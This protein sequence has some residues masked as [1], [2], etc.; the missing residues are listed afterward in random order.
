[1][2][3]TNATGTNTAAAIDF[4]KEWF[5]ISEQP[6]FF[7][8]LANE[9][10]DP[11]EPDERH[12]TT[13]DIEDVTGF[14]SKWNRPKRGSFFCVATL[15]PNTRRNKDNACEICGLH[16]DIDFKDVI[17]DEATILRRLG[18]L[19]LPPSWIVN[20]GNGY[21][22]YWAFKES[23]RIN[24]VDGHETIER[25]EAALKLLCDLVG[26]D[27]KV[28]H[29][30]ALMRMPGTH[31]SKRDEW[32]P[33]TVV[34]STGHRYELDDIETMLSE[35][36]P[37]VLRK[38]RPTS[39]TAGENDAFAKYA[40]EHKLPIDVGQRLKAM[41]YMAGGEAAV[42]TTQLS[43]SASM[44]SSGCTI[45][46]VVAVV[47]GATRLAAGS[48]GE[49]WNWKYEE[50]HTIRGMCESWLR[51]HPRDE[52]K[53]AKSTGTGTAVNDIERLNR[54]HALLPISG[55]TRVV[56]FGELEDFP[57][58][59]T[60]VMTQTIGD[61]VALQNK[62]RHEY[63]DKEGKAQSIPM[64]T[65]WVG[66]QHR[67][68]YD[69]GMAF[70]PQHNKDTVGN[71]MNLWRGYGVR[72]IKPDGKSGAQGC[73]KFLAFMRDVICGGNA[74]HFDYL[75]KREATILQKRIRSEIALGLRSDEEGAGKG[76][77]ERTM[78]HLLGGHAM[79]VGNAKHVVGAFN[80]HLETLLRLTADEA[81]FV[82]NHEHRNVLFGLVTESKLTIEPKGFGIYR[83]DSFLNISVTSNERHFLPVSG[84][85]RRFF[86]PTISQAHL[87]DFAYF[88]AILDQLKNE[89]GY[90]ALLYHFLHEV[91]LTG[92]NVRAVPKT[93]G[94]M[95]QRNHSLLPLEAW[96][97][98]L[99]ETGTIAGADPLE[100]NRAVSHTYQREVTIEAGNGTAQTRLVNQL[101]VYDQAKQVEPRLKSLSDHRLG[102]FLSQM[103][104]ENRV[105]VLRRRGWTFPPLLQCRDEWEK[106]FPNWPWVDPA[107]EAWRAEEADDPVD[108]DAL[109]YE[110]RAELATQ[111]ATWAAAHA[112]RLAKEAEHAKANAKFQPAG[113]KPSRDKEPRF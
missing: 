4:V 47:L 2:D 54:L 14:L 103:G 65:Y 97:C 62:Y 30:A 88:S 24:I 57:G 28:C 1:M 74:E 111:A 63:L 27:F 56:T 55:K 99:L 36:S 3:K 22:C 11:T 95:E 66:S 44:L 101:G 86:I 38:E 104:C 93:E 53:Q 82:G 112:E 26:G 71:R 70:M 7:N 105:K 92:F 10:G 91:D 102:A 106:R 110:A 6:A 33:V 80:P 100:P 87:Q 43:V 81:L 20:S 77:Y 59:E 34:E 76:I 51:K 68:Q 113:A 58:R 78:G 29:V 40:S 107:I 83:A 69:G 35:T 50:K 94:L 90:E 16:A 85:A 21:H 31:N 39:K 45:D 18:Q 19:L 84:T 64:G 49:R 61:F 48:Y 13:R 25:I 32:K 98:E 12:V 72:A 5:G 60:I 79:Q 96:W 8:S 52:N 15:Q 108:L 89:G 41:S 17:D 9:K 67:R 75:V 109:T 37:I 42:H 46:E 73:D 23:I